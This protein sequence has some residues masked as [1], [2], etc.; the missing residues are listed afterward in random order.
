[1]CVFNSGEWKAIDYTR[2]KG[3]EAKFSKV[4]MNVAYLPAF[5][6]NHKI[7]PAGDALILS[8]SGKVIIKKPDLNNSITVEISATTYRVTKQSTDFI[9]ENK[10]ITGKKYTLFYWDNEWIKAGNKEV[11]GEVLLF[12]NIPS[13]TF[14][15]L[16]AEDSREEERIFTIN[17][18]G[19]QVWW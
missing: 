16:I 14:Y 12:E 7:I 15:W 17:E 13:N 3:A 19:K 11:M 10:L 4:G 6:H 18:E 2:F 5:Y 1:L 9:A 8:D